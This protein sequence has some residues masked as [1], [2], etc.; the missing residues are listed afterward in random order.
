MTLDSKINSILPQI[1]ELYANGNPYELSIKNFTI[2]TS[3][4]TD[5]TVCPLT[6]RICKRDNTNNNLLNFNDEWDLY[7]AECIVCRDDITIN[8]QIDPVY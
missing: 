2:M 3:N 5:F 1:K 8:Y 6:C 4:Q 7:D